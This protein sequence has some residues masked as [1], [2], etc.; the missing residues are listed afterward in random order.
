MRVQSGRRV[1]VLAGTQRL[2]SDRS[3][4]ASAAGGAA[5]VRAGIANR[6]GGVEAKMSGSAGE[7][8]KERVVVRSIGQ[9]D[10]AIQT[11]R[12]RPSS[13]AS[14]RRSFKT[15]AVKTLTARSPASPRR[16]GHEPARGLHERVELRS[17]RL[18]LRD[19]SRIARSMRAACARCVS[20]R[21]ARRRSRERP[22]RARASASAHRTTPAAPRREP[23]ARP[24]AR[25]ATDRALLGRETLARSRRPRAATPRA[26]AR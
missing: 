19:A 23:S 9:E 4:A 22:R 16:P 2:F 24:R 6:S 18:S 26:P 25:R 12:S 5:R 11:R 8:V 3:I 14:R 17:A 1:G 10:R 13:P 7:R 21:A 20:A 15:P